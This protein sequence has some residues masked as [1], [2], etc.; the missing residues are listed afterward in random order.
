M[1]TVVDWRVSDTAAKT[2]LR[3]NVSRKPASIQA[4]PETSAP[5]NA[6]E[7]TAVTGEDERPQRTGQPVELVQGD[8]ASQRDEREEKPAAEIRAAEDDREAGRHDGDPRD[9]GAHRAAE[10]AAAARVLGEGLPEVPLA[11][12]GPE[13]VHEHELRVGELPEEE[14][15]DPQLPRGADQKVGLGH[16]GRVE[17][18]ADGVL[19]DVARVDPFLD[20][21]PRGLDDLRAA[22]VVE[23]DPELEPLVVRGLL[24]EAGHSPLELRVGAVA[25]A[26][27]AR[28]HALLARSGSSRSIVSTKIS[29]SASTSS[30]GRDQFS[31]ENAK[32]QRDSTPR[33]IAASTVR[34]SAFVPARCPAAT[35]RLRRRAQRPLP[36][37]MIAIERAT[38]GSSCSGPAFAVPRV[39]SFVMRFML[40]TESA[41]QETT[42]IRP[43]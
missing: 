19:V 24:L 4:A 8:Q 36:S 29:I 26:D 32:T 1:A 17:P 27:E 42:P 7:R 12:V 16:L 20:E 28:R 39:R 9:Q 35:G 25:A 43:P 10:A 37:M 15:R 41:P 23:R 5:K 40:V 33:S 38:S 21:P 2:K 30:G 13:R 14:V 22:A 34:R 6:G 11:E 3:T 31:V 18:R